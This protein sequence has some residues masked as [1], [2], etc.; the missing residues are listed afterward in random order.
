[1][2]RFWLLVYQIGV[3]CSDTF[4]GASLMIAPAFTMKRMGV[5]VD[6][7]LLVYIGYI[8]AFVLGVGL[9]CAYGALVL[10]VRGD[11]KRVQMVWL[12]TAFVRGSVAAF[13]A[14]HVLSHQLAPQWLGVAIF[15]G[16]CALVQ[17]F[18]LRREWLNDVTC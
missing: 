1:M 2:K 5:S 7:A 14:A 4:T 16:V 10:L 18:G 12:L 17:G 9:S 13:V 15:D 3:A 6:P 8:G 11:N